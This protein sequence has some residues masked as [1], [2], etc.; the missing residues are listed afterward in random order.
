MKGLRDSDPH[1]KLLTRRSRVELE[2]VRA[3]KTGRAA[4]AVSSSAKLPR[5]V[6]PQ[7][8]KLVTEIPTGDDWAHEIK[9]DGYRMA[10]R[11]EDGSA[12]LLTRTGLDW[13]AR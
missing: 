6:E 9:F 7:L 2:R 11:I 12:T 10:A 1:S 3:K 13:T 8:T 4:A 5:W